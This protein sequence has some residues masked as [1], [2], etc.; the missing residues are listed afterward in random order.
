MTT[1][2]DEFTQWI[3]SKKLY[4]V[5]HLRLDGTDLPL[6]SKPTWSLQHFNADGSPSQAIGTLHTSPDCFTARFSAEHL[7]T[8]TVTISAVVSPTMV[9]SKTFKITVAPH[10]PVTTRAPTFKVTQHRNGPVH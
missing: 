4:H 6:V 2:P 3:D 5:D 8:V 1:E 7:G 10:P 9:A